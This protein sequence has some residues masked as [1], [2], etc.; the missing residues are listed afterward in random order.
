M[1]DL[2]PKSDS[3]YYPTKWKSHVY[4]SLNETVAPL[5]NETILYVSEDHALEEFPEHFFNSSYSKAQN[6]TLVGGIT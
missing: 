1:G 6:I 5:L 3:R 2:G 4:V